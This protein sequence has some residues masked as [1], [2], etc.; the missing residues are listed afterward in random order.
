MTLVDLPTRIVRLFTTE[1]TPV[2]C[3][4][5]H[6]ETELFKSGGGYSYCSV[7]CERDDADDQVEAP[8]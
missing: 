5:C 4:W 2:D 3:H 8:F 7:K 1:R 6:K